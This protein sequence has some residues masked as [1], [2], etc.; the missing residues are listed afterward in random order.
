MA[1][2]LGAS[3]WSFPGLEDPDPFPPVDCV[4]DGADLEPATIVAAY[5]AGLFPMGD[6]R[7][8][9]LWWSPMERGIL[10]PEQVRVSRSLRRS[11][12]RFRTSVDVAFADVID[13]C[14]D[15]S[16]PGAWIDPPIRAAYVELHELGWAHS[17][18]VWD[19]DGDL[20]GGLYG[21][22]FGGVFAG[23]SMFHR[24]TDASKVALVD[25]CERMR[26]GLIDVQWTTPHLASLG[27]VT[28][29]RGEYRRLLAE[30]RDDPQPGAWT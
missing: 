1:E 16:R 12:H 7:G 27:V 9:P 10:W 20:V 8:V 26:G 15:P 19:A 30:R 2:D 11:M 18:E 21:L 22:A 4:A 28:V 25:L 24:A 3:V 29:T 14:A 5:R 6:Q 23:E 13:A 17:V